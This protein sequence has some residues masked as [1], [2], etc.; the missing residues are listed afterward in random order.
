MTAK[1]TPVTADIFASITE[2]MALP[3]TIAEQA[4]GMLKAQTELLSGMEEITRDW[5][6]RRREANEQAIRAAERICSSNDPSEM[7]VTYFDW[8]GGS[9]RRLTD[10][11]TALS[12]KAFAVTASATKA[13][14]NGASA[15]LRSKAG[16]LR[17][18]SRGKLKIKRASKA[19]SK[20]ALHAASAASAQPVGEAKQRLAG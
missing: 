1:K 10:D 16:A 2:N 17:P 15:A 19:E 6:Q 5:L 18:G 13:G 4:D 20:V 14:G 7:M 12:E 9:L 11:V 3:Q 8:L